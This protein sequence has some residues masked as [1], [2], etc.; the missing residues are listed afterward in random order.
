MIRLLI[1]FVLM[2]FSAI[3]IAAAGKS[4]GRV[5]MEAAAT[6]PFLAGA[7]AAA[8]GRL[9]GDLDPKGVGALQRRIYVFGHEFTHAVA[10]WGSGAK[11]LGFKAGERSGHVDL[12][13]S[14][15]AVA[16]APYCVPIY[17]LAAVLGYRL[18]VWA[19]PDLSG[20][21]VF[22]FLMGLTLAFHM[23][24]TL[25]CLWD[26]RQ[27]DLKDAGGV[28]FSLAWIAASNAL[29]VMLMLKALFPKVVPLGAELAASGR[30]A[31]ALVSWGWGLAL[32]IVG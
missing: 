6:F 27:P 22:P 7:G 1:G 20:P 28:V 31:G 30:L 29:L 26:A 24:A 9:A 15:A 21:S 19:R 11:V 12:S 32:R 10:A 16:L 5:C 25:E 2:P 3:L 8:L 14:N 18:L 23:I 4:L 17:A 13:H